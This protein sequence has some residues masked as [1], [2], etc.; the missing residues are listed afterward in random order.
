[1]QAKKAR[2]P[3]G[4]GGESYEVGRPAGPL[5]LVVHGS[6]IV[7]R[8]LRQPHEAFFALPREAFPG[9][10]HGFKHTPVLSGEGGAGEFPA[11]SRV[12]VVLRC[13]LQASPLPRGSG[14]LQTPVKLD[15]SQNPG[16][17]ILRTENK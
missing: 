9:P 13:F 3:G 5:G 8:F 7:R 1:M 4:N 6:G 12:L 2:I 15:R 17:N 14:R 10:G 11:L 16:K